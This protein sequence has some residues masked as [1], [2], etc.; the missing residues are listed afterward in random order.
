MSLT[1]H[2]YLPL[3]LFYYAIS[4]CVLEVDISVFYQTHSVR[5]L[6]GFSE[7]G[8]HVILEVVGLLVSLVCLVS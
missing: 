3:V 5:G 1:A 7:Y 8:I 6:T 4:S 2:K